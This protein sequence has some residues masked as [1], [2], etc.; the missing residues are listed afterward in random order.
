MTTAHR[1]ARRAEFHRLFTLMPGKTNAD[2][3]RAVCEAACVKPTTVYQWKMAN[4][5]RVPSERVLVML[6]RSVSEA[7][8]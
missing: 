2:R 5:P 1:E 8:G 7:A 6:R 3:L 4:P